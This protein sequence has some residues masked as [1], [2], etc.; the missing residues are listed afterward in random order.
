MTVKTTFSWDSISARAISVNGRLKLTVQR[1]FL[2]GFCLVTFVRAYHRRSFGQ[3]IFRET[4][5]IQ[6]CS[7][8]CVGASKIVANM[9]SRKATWRPACCGER[10]PNKSFAYAVRGSGDG[11]GNG[12]QLP[13][14][15]DA[16][17][18]R[19]TQG[20]PLRGLNGN[21]LPPLAP[22]QRSPSQLTDY[23][24][25]GSDESAEFYDSTTADCSKRYSCTSQSDNSSVFDGEE[26]IDS[27]SMIEQDRAPR[28]DCLHSTLRYP[29]SSTIRS[30][31]ESQYTTADDTLTLIVEAENDTLAR[32]GRVPWE[33]R[34]T[35]RRQDGMVRLPGLQ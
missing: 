33:E 3:C 7:S 28:S 20:I 1:V 2:C 12:I 27:M 32:E 15:Y 19:I 13:T 14:H 31:G 26:L 29:L 5:C 18:A 25:F 8:N 35:L 10:L 6:I 4:Y 30:M 21:V 24:Y 16:P 9:S 22:R 11:E 23:S 34:K 17:R